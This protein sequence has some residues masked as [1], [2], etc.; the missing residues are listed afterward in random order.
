MKRSRGGGRDPRGGGRDNFD[1]DDDRPKK[2]GGRNFPDRFP[3]H[4]L[5]CPFYQ[6]H[7][8]KYTKAAC[9]GLGFVD[10]AK[11]K[12][13]IKQVHTQPLRCS[14][15]W[16]EM[17]SDEAYSE[18]VQQESI[19]AKA[20]EPVDDRIRPQSLKNL[21]F[22][23]APYS[24]ASNAEEKWK[25]MFKVL[26][27]GDSTVPSPYEQQ[28]MNPQ[29]EHALYEAVEEELTRELALVMEP[30]M[31]KIKGCIPAIIERCREKLRGS[32]SLSED[33]SVFTP[34]STPPTSVASSGKNDCGST[35]RRDSPQSRFPTYPCSKEA[36]E[37]PP[38]DQNV[39]DGTCGNAVQPSVSCASYTHAIEPLDIIAAETDH[40]TGRL[41]E[42]G[43]SNFDPENFNTAE[44]GDVPGLGHGWWHPMSF[45]NA[46]GHHPPSASISKT[47]PVSSNDGTIPEP[48]QSGKNMSRQKSSSLP[49]H[50]HDECVAQDLSW[51][52]GT[53]SQAD[54]FEKRFPSFDSSQDW[55]SFMKDFDTSPGPS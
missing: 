45:V 7:P 51:P 43:T 5:K 55:E 47:A 33:E 10:M 29:L 50:V 41:D 49:S 44:F 3:Q 19:C 31:T 48:D 24:N 15:C 8:D 40:D 18:H 35:T 26:F 22:K 17:E 28:G 54:L 21:D 37:I 9:R 11:L 23:K 20:P 53:A 1:D 34:L 38:T 42:Y 36:H 39:S 32:T 27:P 25:M 13:H 12:D 4:R 52:E 6:R 16:L 2:K 14:R 46:A 30:I